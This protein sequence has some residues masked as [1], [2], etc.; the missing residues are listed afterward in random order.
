MNIATKID[1]AG[2]TSAPAPSWARFDWQDPL[3]LES[4]LTPEER[5]VRDTARAFCD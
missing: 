1:L 2:A 4:Q 5:M 3:L